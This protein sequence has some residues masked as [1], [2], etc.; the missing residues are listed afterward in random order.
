MGAKQILRIPLSAVLI[1]LLA[2]SCGSSEQGP[3]PTPRRAPPGFWPPRASEGPTPSVLGDVIDV[4]GGLVRVGYWKLKSAQRALVAGACDGPNEPTAGHRTYRVQVAPFRLMKSEVSN[5]VYGS[6]VASG[7]CAPPDADLSDDPSGAIPWNDPRRAERSAAVSQR[8][9]RAFCQA[10]GGDLPTYYQ[11]IRSAEGDGGAFGIKLLS[12]TWIRCRLGEV[13]PLCDAVLS[14]PW[15]LAASEQKPDTAVY[16]PLTDPT[17]TPWDVGPYGHVGLFGGAGEWIRVDPAPQPI[18]SF[19]ESEGYLS[20]DFIRASYE[21]PPDELV[22]L[23]Q[24]GRDLALMGSL[25]APEAEAIAA[26]QHGD[27]T[28]PAGK[29][30]Y[31]T[32]VRCAFPPRVGP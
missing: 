28:E 25:T 18:K 4:P 8:L 26:V 15:A 32:G 21:S 11:W 23:M 30:R 22:P 14:A 27:D 3:T 1:S 17:A 20:D 31:F 7:A 16:R 10:Q 5:R 13:L 24:I 12:E 9:G 19:C 6:C 2:A 29:G